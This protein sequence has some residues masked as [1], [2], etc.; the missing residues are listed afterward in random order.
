LGGTANHILISA[1]AN[2][3]PVWSEITTLISTSS[4]TANDPAYDVLTLGNKGDV[5]TT[6]KHSEGNIVLYSAGKGGYTIS[7]T[8]TAND[9]AVTF[10][11]KTGWIAIGDS[12]GVGNNTK[13]IY[14]NEHGVL[15]ASN[16]S[17]G[18]AS[19]IIYLNNGTLT[20]SNTSVGS[21]T[22]NVYLKE[23]VITAQ[24]YTA[25]RLCYSASTTNLGYDHYVSA[26][27]IAINT[28]TAPT[29]TLYINGSTKTTSHLTIGEGLGNRNI[30]YHGTSGAVN[31]ITFRD[32]STAAKYPIDIGSGET[33][34]LN[35]SSFS[36]SSKASNT[37]YLLADNVINLEVKNAETS[38]D[39]A[40]VRRG[41]QIDAYGNVVPTKTE[42]T[43]NN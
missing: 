13:F 34:F 9:R 7:G 41:M 4:S 22:S 23:G 8:S 33:L 28:T 32:N 21:N 19:K 37:I 40:S 1:G 25:N 35:A 31:M 39:Q 30:I 2:A 17:V 12:A 5:T 11:D 3:T 20:E 29:E 26:T 24:T 10:P 6:T 18:S 15:T 38:G 42:G 43:N 27:K 36:I 16:A 14:L